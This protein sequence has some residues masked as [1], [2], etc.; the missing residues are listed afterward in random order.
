MRRSTDNLE[1]G[2][3]VCFGVAIFFGCMSSAL[4]LSSGCAAFQGQGLKAVEAATCAI[5]DE[6]LSVAFTDPAKAKAY[7]KALPARLKAGEPEALEEAAAI[8]ISLADC[9]PEASAP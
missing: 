2:A 4:S 6:T 5:E 1:R 8:A 7:L 9:I 3:R